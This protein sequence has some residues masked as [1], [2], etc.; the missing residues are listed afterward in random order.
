MQERGGVALVMTTTIGLVVTWA[1]GC[2]KG[3]QRPPQEPQAAYSTK[4]NYPKPTFP[5]ESVLTVSFDRIRAYADSLHFETT[6]GAADELLIDFKRN[7]VG[8]ERAQVMRIEPESA[9]YRIGAR[10]PVDLVVGGQERSAWYVALGVHRGVW[11]ACLPDRA[12]GS[13]PADGPR[14]W[15]LAPSHRPFLGGEGPV[16]TQRS[17]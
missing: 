8:T 16:A 13:A 2:S 17:H 6:L 7:R 11:E 12:D 15:L 4:P 1:G 10:D 14:Q 5:P 3:E 9:S